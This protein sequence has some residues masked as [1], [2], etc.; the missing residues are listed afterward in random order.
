[1]AAPE[2]VARAHQHRQKSITLAAIAAVLALWRLIDQ[3]R[4]TGSWQGGIGRSIV[5]AMASA[6]LQAAA[7]V[8]AYL[9]D[10]AEA[11]RIAAP[12]LE[13]VPAAFSGIASDGRPLETLMY[14]P[15][16]AFKRLVADGATEAEAMRRATALMTMIAATQA[17][18]VGRTAVLAGVAA[19][20]RWVAYTRV[21]TLPACSRCIVLAGR[22]YSHSTG[23]ER[24]PNCDCGMQPVTS[25]DVD[26]PGPTA[27]F[28]QMSAED[29]NRRF[30]KAGAEAIRLGADPGQVVNAR[31]GMR[32]A[33]DGRLVTREGI[34]RRGVAGRRLQGAVRL[35]PETLIAEAGGDRNAAIEGLRRHGFLLRAAT[36]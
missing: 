5:Q 13:V 14:Q 24:H 26:I 12:A 20:P 21:V 7:L 1:M 15:I 25:D 31:R 22:T 6:Q 23:F 29:Q 8:P 28:N 27:L 16:I 18:D 3:R 9:R 10:L 36:T 2:E 33:A 35:M 4:L 11:Q 34:S 32:T 17:A 19:N 30:G